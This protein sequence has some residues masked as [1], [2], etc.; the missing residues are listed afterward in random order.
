M[1]DQM[2]IQ[3]RLATNN[4]FKATKGADVRFANVGDE[5]MCGISN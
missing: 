4:I 3:L 2:L 1:R 5:P